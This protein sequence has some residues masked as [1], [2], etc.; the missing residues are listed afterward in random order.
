MSIWMISWRCSKLE[1]GCLR[2][3]ASP[4]WQATHPPYPRAFAFTP[5]FEVYG[6][7]RIQGGQIKSGFRCCGPLT[8]L[9]AAFARGGTDPGQQL[10]SHAWEQAELVHTCHD[11]RASAMPQLART[12][13]RV[14]A[15]WSTSTQPWPRVT[16]LLTRVADRCLG[17]Q[18]NR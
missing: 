5:Y 8:R 2:S 10:R 3:V 1:F 16:Y 17:N 12:L 13:H 4:T 15:D 14:A 9:A 6:N 18:A 11:H 7:G